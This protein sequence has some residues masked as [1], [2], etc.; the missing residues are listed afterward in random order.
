MAKDSAPSAADRRRAEIARVAADLFEER[1][2]HNTSMEVIGDAVGVRKPTLYHY[3]PSKDEIL[4][5]IHDEFI[6][7]L[8]ERQVRRELVAMPADQALREIMSDILELMETHR[9][10]VRVFF[11]H[12]RELSDKPYQAIAEKRNRYQ[13]MVRDVFV[14]GSK[15]GLLR[16]SLD[17]DMATLALAGMCNWAY[18][19]YRP[20]Y[21]LGSREIAYVFWDFLL[22]G[23]AGD[24]AATRKAGAAARRRRAEPA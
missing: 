18:Q 2:Y 6:E 10:H 15:D 19:W 3:F 9:G 5:A 13:S 7:L 22:H 1:G 24:P 11:E 16:E 21:K 14:T 12:H 20:N 17:P 8:I 23:I 4:Y